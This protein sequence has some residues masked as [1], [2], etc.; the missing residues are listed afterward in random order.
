VY[1]SGGNEPRGEREYGAGSL[2]EFDLLGTQRTI[3][4]VTFQHSS[5]RNGDR[6]LIGGYA[7]IGFGR[8]GVLAEHDVTDRERSEIIGPFRQHASYAQLFWAVRDW[9]VASATG[10]SLRVSVPYQEKLTAGKIEVASRVT[11]HATVIAGGRVE[12]NAA[13]GRL[14]KSLTVQLSLKTVD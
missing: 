6:R 4:G 10:E 3:L 2:A 12:H 1:G 13:N 9:L 5:A 11:S 14:S 8:W 7:R